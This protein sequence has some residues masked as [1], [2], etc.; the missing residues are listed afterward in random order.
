MAEKVKKNQYGIRRTDFMCFW[1][2]EGQGPRL[3]PRRKM[4]APAD[5][6]AQA[7]VRCGF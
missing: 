4:Y 2:E 7:A 5:L 6:V 1:I 3:P